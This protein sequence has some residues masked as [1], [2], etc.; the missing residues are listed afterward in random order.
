MTSRVCVRC[1][2]PHHAQRLC[3]AHY[4]RA[5]RR[6]LLGPSLASG[7][8]LAV[9]LRWVLDTPGWNLSRVAREARVHRHTVTSV[10][11]CRHLVQAATAARIAAVCHTARVGG[12]GVPA[13]APP[14]EPVAAHAA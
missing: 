3:R 4:N 6:G 10:L 14:V 1:G 5:A 7:V 2:A 9:D 13:G 12:L 11:R 8:R